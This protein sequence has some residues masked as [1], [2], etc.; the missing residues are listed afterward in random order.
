MSTVER[1]Q[2]AKIIPTG[3]WR[4]DPAHSSVGFAVKH[5]MIATVRGQFRTFDGTLEADA[6]RAVRA[7]GSIAA[8]SID[9]G[10]RGRDEHLRSADFLDVEAYPEIRFDA[11]SIEP[12]H[13]GTLRM[14]GYL[15][16]R[17]V[18]RVVELDVTL[19]GVGRDPWGNDRLALE[20]RG[21]ID[22]EEFGLTWNQALE[23]G[24]VL[25]G[26]KVQLELDLSTVRETE[27]EA[28]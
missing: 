9:T 19:H 2:S 5:M 8:A 22:R 25:V 14:T 27:W 21:E 18:S 28:A 11:R 4:V 17:G 3:V 12:L 6:S 7:R 15:S 20:I 23:S 24:G 1:T 13:D 16:I 10:E 26:R